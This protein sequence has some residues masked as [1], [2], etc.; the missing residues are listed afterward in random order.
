MKGFQKSYLRGL[1]QTLRPAVHAG[2][3]GVDDALVQEVN[4]T[5]EQQELI[6]VKFTALKEQ[7]KETARRIAEATGSEMVGMV[8][9][10]AIFYREHPDPQERQ[11][12]LPAR[13]Q[14]ASPG[15]E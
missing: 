8:G 11:I 15:P 12:R 4:R 14:E 6:K 10:T 3:K 2:K 9:H 1:G 5:F 7:K 13:E